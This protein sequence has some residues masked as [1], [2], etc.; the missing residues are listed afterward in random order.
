MATPQLEPLRVGRVEFVRT[1]G[2]EV[3]VRFHGKA[4]VIDGAVNA[5]QLE[6]WAV[7]QLRDGVFGPVKQPEPT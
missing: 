4:G 7:R 2:D 5:C 6:R 3:V 1:E